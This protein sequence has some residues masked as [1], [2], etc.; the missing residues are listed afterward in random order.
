MGGGGNSAG[1]TATTEVA[2]AVG[3]SASVGMTARVGAGEDT[4]A[5]P[6]RRMTPPP[7]ASKRGV[8]FNE[9]GSTGWNVGVRTGVMVGVGV[10]GK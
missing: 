9:A 10:V 4:G 2:A 3:V 6:G 8:S 1:V 5:S 7:V